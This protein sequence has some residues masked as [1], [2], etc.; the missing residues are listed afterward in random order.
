MNPKDVSNLW[1]SSGGAYLI[2]GISWL[3]RAIFFSSI[4]RNVGRQKNSSNDGCLLTIS[5]TVFVLIGG[6]IGLLVFNKY[7]PWF[8]FTSILGSLLAPWLVVRTFKRGKQKY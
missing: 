6:A 5:T 7:F 3:V 2:I 1:L 8:I 4:A